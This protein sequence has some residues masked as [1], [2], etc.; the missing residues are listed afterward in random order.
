M[1][2]L[3]PKSGSA[4]LCALLALACAGNVDARVTERAKQK[5]A[6]EAR[7]AGIQQQQ[8]ALQKEIDRTESAKDDA[9]D[10]LAES[11]SAISDANRAL[12]DLKQEQLDTNAKLQSLADEQERLAKTIETQKQQLAAL[13]RQHYVAGNEDRL[14]LLLSGD[15]PNRINRDL[16][17]MAYVSK[18]RAKLLESLRA[19]LAQVEANRDKVQEAKDEL[20]EIEQ[21]KRDAK[22][23]LEQEKGRRATL[24]ASLST[25]L[26]AQRKQA[27]KL[28]QDDKRLAGLVD[29]LAKIIHEQELAAAAERKRQEALA[30]ARAKAA[31]EAKAAAA[32]RAKA[33]RERL[34]QQGKPG[35]KP[36]PEPESPK[37]V[38]EPPAPEKAE[39]PPKIL[40]P[41]PEG[42]FASLKGRLVVPIDGKIEARFG[43]KRPEGGP[44]WQAMFIKA[45]EG[46]E[47]RA[48]GPGRVIKAIWLRAYGN[49]IIIDHGGGYWSIYGYN[50]TLLKNE[51]DMVKA[52]E[53]IATAG[54][55]GG[56]EHSGL[57]FSMLFKGKPF[58][59]QTWIHF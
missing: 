15:N 41:L 4:L 53:A 30:A 54:N 58:D 59:P 1:R 13:L 25:K 18:A 57:F 10:A 27:S 38:E 52:G 26:A 8:Q 49:M 19:N 46:T 32:A 34:A 6:A 48:I 47:V 16:Q 3:V 14:K 17:M 37:V 11:E 22:A 29:Q 20:E 36:L 9:S 28:E 23:R 40:P 50:Q 51:G 42:Q 31:A 39:P 43:S 45:A 12:H 21:D 55:T 35:A 2:S 7:R 56:I 24:L 5:A 33:E 44:V